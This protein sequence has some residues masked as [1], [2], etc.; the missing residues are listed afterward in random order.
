[1][2][3]ASYDIMLNIREALHLDDE[4]KMFEDRGNIHFLEVSVPSVIGDVEVTPYSVDHSAFDAFMLL[5]HAGDEYILHTGDFRDHGHKGNKNGN[6]II[7][8]VIEH[9]IRQHGLRTISALILEGTMMNR[10]TERR[11]SEKDMFRELTKEFKDNKYVFL[12]ISST[13]AD[14]LAS[15]AKAAERNGMKMYV[16]QYMQAQMDVYR[17]VGAAHGT[18]MY[19]FSNILPYLPCPDDC[20]SDR[21]RKSSINQRRHMRQNGFIILISEKGNYKKM[22]D[23]FSDLPTKTYYSMWKGYITPRSSAFNEE[24][25]NLCEYTHADTSHH[26]SGH[27]YPELLEKVILAVNPT[28]A[29]IPIHTEKADAFLNLNIPVE[30]KGRMLLTI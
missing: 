4:V 13:N 3:K 7:I 21:Q 16:G 30:F 8:K 9:Y 20:T 18:D 25:Y 1:M 23:E 15:F 29:I 22:V 17:A 11:Y 6:S 5:V 12:K 2:G 14:S 24:L 10:S 28:E 27:A 19:S 26:T